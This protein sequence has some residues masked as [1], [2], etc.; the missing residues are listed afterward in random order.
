MFF[1]ILQRETH[2]LGL[3]PWFLLYE[4]YLQRENV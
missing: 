4:Y 3:V 2:L 1:V